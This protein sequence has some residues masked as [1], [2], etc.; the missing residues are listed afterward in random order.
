MNFFLFLFYFPPP[1]F[2]RVGALEKALASNPNYCAYMCEP[3]QGEAG[4]VVPDAGYMRKAKEIC[5]KYNVLLIADEVS[6]IYVCV[7]V[8]VCVCVYVCMCVCVC[9]CVCV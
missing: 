4:V 7:C 5:K 8:C 9:V 1:F 2:Q 3:I 6:R